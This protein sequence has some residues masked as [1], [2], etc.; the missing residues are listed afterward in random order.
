MNIIIGKAIISALCSILILMMWYFR[1]LLKKRIANYSML[2][3]F[4]MGVL[5]FRVIPY[6]IIFFFLSLPVPSDISYYW[7]DSIPVFDGKLV[8]RDFFCPYAPFFPYIIALAIKFWY[9]PKAISLLMMVCEV[10]ILFF[11]VKQFKPFYKKEELLYRLLI[12][13]V[14]PASLVLSALSGQEDIWMWFFAVLAYRFSHS[15]NAAF[16]M[17]LIMGIG[18]LFTKAVLVLGTISIFFFIRKRISFL[19]GLVIVGL[20]TLVVLYALTGLE[21]LQPI[22]ESNTLRSPNIGSVLN[23]FF[24]NNLHLG[25]KWLNWLGLTIIIAISGITSL[26][27]PQK[28]LLKPFALIWIITYGSMMI[29]QQSA[30]SNYIF[31]FLMPLV[32]TLLDT[33]KLSELLILLLFNVATVIQPSIWWRYNMPQYKKPADIFARP[34]F[35]IDY[36]MQ[37]VIV[38]CVVYYIYSSFQFLKKTSKTLSPEIQ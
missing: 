14:M 23:P 36:T 24:F 2:S 34:E 16:K 25:E 35:I 33:E 32:F 15:K 20:P 30:Y 12:Y 26:Y 27:S 11:T 21:F 22:Q 31:I 10:G 17:G 19:L 3:V 6:L 28:N 4:G 37:V 5:L 9:S 18:H 38:G 7:R 1:G 8:Y 29:V 13:L